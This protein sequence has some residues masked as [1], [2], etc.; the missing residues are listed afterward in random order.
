METETTIAQSIRATDTRARYDAACKRL[1]SEKIILA[2]IMKSCL[3]EY[4][5]CT[6]EEIAERYIEGQPQVGEVPVGIDESVPVIRGLRNED[7]TLTE[8]TVTY[9]IRFYA[10]A[11][12]SGDLIRLII[13]TELQNDYYPGYP[14]T[15]RGIYYCSRMISA[16]YGTEFTDAH[17]E[18]LKKVYSI[19]ICLEPPKHRQNTITRYRMV[20]ENLV[21]AV[22]EPVRNYDLLSMVMLGLGGSEEA[23]YG[24]VLRLLD[25]LLSSKTS[26]DEKR[27]ILQEDYDIRMTQ[28]LEEEVSQMCDLSK[29]IWDKAMA[30]G[31]AKGEARG[32]AVGRAEGKAEGILTSLKSLME[33]M[34]W[35]IEQAMAA[36]KVPEDERDKYTKLMKTSMSQN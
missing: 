20:E 33:T 28:T 12:V 29:G 4:R 30:E 23:N 10:T 5:D 36:M 6:V 17:Y 25:V 8:G 27:Q 19:F 35:T 13:N 24:G 34:S 18:K 26:A 31:E 22:Q 11:P 15:K 32:K 21:G 7:K 9:D 14:L 16:Q 2:W 3:E 1:L